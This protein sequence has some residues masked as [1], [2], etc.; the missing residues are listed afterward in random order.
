MVVYWTL[1]SKKV[2]EMLNRDKVY[3]PNFALSPQVHSETYSKLLHVFNK[4]NSTNYEG[5]IFCLFK[6][7][8][9]SFQDKE[10]FFNYFKNRP[11]VLDALNNG[12]YPLFSNSHVLV[13]VETDCF[14]KENLNHCVVDFWNFIMMIPDE[15]GVAENAYY[16]HQWKCPDLEGVEYLDFVNLLWDY[17]YDKKL[18]SPLVMSTAFQAVIPYLDLNK[19]KIETFELF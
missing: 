18:F 13:R 1:Q 19:M 17:M 12:C 9:N 2:I 5:L 3:Y 8:G 10:E 16:N 6:D 15:Q 7:D 11:T 4:S 14:I